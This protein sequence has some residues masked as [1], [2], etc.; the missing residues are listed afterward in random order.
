M[1][2]IAEHPGFPVDVAFRQLQAVVRNG[3]YPVILSKLFS[4]FFSLPCANAARADPLR[5]VAHAHGGRAASGETAARRCATQS[6]SAQTGSALPGTHA[7][8]PAPCTHTHRASGR[9]GDVR[10]TFGADCLRSPA[11]TSVARLFEHRRCP[12]CPSAHG[13][14]WPGAKC[15]LSAPGNKT[16]R[17]AKS[18]NLFRSR[19]SGGSTAGL[20]RVR[21]PRVRTPCVFCLPPRLS[22]ALLF[23]P[24]ASGGSYVLSRTVD[25]LR[26]KAPSFNLWN[27]KNRQARRPFRH[28]A[29]KA[30]GVPEPGGFFAGK[31]AAAPN[32][33]RDVSWTRGSLQKS[34]ASWSGTAGARCE[35]QTLR[36]PDPGL[37]RP[38]L[39]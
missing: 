26:P 29:T 25:T 7:V 19:A 34:R 11:I 37:D 35:N 3:R 32:H 24:G 39:L 12:L 18:R 33:A 21:K 16:I 4:S 1:L 30:N 14:P 23:R 17:P 9:A 27:P 2:R 15:A 38:N 13:A 31:P 28:L 36:R 10:H 20:R 6:L 5:M 8:R 22:G